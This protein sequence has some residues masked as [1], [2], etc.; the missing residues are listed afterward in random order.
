MVEAILSG[1]SGVIAEVPIGLD[2]C[3]FLEKEKIIIQIDTIKKFFVVR[4]DMNVASAL[5]E[6]PC[7]WRNGCHQQEAWETALPIY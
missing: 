4:C 6:Q 2:A 7:L 5:R 1:S 3:S